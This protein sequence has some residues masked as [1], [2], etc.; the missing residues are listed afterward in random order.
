MTVNEATMKLGRWGLKLSPDTPRA[1]LDRIDYFGHIA[2]STGRIDPR[3]AGD[4]LL[5]SARYVGV[6]RS[7]QLADEGSGAASTLGGCS[8]AFWLGDEAKKG[9][10]IENATPFAS[11]SFTSTVRAL[12][13]SSGAVVEGTLHSVTGLYN[14]THQY[15]DPRTAISYVCEFFSSSSSDPVEWRVNGDATLDAGHVSDLYETTPKAAIVRRG[16][17][18]DMNLRALAGKATTAVDVED[19]TTRVVLLAN[20]TGGSVATG[21]ADISPG[22]NT[23]K[24]LHGNTVVMTRLVSESSTSQG[25][26]TSRAQLSL[27]RF[28]A[29][30][31]ALTLSSG[32]Y[33]VRGTASVGDAVWVWNPDV[34]LLD[35]N[36][37]ILHRG[38][39]INPVKL[40]LTEMTW[41]IAE[42]MSVAYRDKNGGW[43]DLTDYVQWES[44][45][46]TLVVGGYDRSLTNTGG[47]PVGSR[48]VRDTSVPG[49]PAF[50]TGAFV[51]SVYQS[52]NTG[53]TKARVQL[54]WTQPTN[55]DGTV[56]IDGDRYELRYRTSAHSIFPSL[57]E[58][59]AGFNWE[60]LDTWDQPINLGE[61][62]WHYLAVS[63]DTTQFL[64][65]E[66]TPGV[67]Y[68]FQIRAADNASPANLSDWSA[69]TTI[70]THG[71]TI[72][73]A[74]PAPPTVAASL[75]AVQ[76]I[77]TL[78]ISEGGTY[79]LDPDLHHLEVHAEYEPTFTPSDATR[80][81]KLLANVGMMIGEIPVVGTLPVESTAALYFKVIAVDEAGNK[82]SPS[83]AV[84]ATADLIDNAHISDLS[85]SKLT[86]GTVTAAYVHAG[87]LRIGAGTPGDGI[88]PA[89]ELT[90][91]SIQAFNPTDGLTFNLD[92]ATGDVRLSGTV[93]GKGLLLEA[94]FGGKLEVKDGGNVTRLIARHD[95]V[96]I[97]DSTGNEVFSNTT[98]SDWGI[99]QPNL[100][101]A[102][103][104][105]NSDT[106]TQNNTVD[107]AYYAKYL[108]GHI[109]NHARVNFGVVCSVSGGGATGKYRVR[110][111]TG[112]PGNGGNPSG[113]TLMAERTGIAQGSYIDGYTYDWPSNMFG[114]L[115][116]IAY[117]VGLTSGVGGSDWVSATPSH[118]FGQ[119]N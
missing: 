9:A 78:G 52:T 25:N 13:P 18:L 48:P 30:R 54:V 91:G 93:Y 44:G 88:G 114:Q 73:P 105:V 24:D 39:R 19:F 86:A 99:T 97:R 89:V 63:F 66:L 74:T 32:E 96:T 61:G 95:E 81:G 94:G 14:N 2:I 46:T 51:Q 118:F 98:A 75:I 110:W 60:D 20:G 15:Q 41:P 117:E 6:L 111:Y 23:Y 56:I 70:Q 100:Q 4:S 47:E 112:H 82:S 37:E 17:G 7:R 92:A 49:T 77:H 68:D 43:V 113:G 35:E 67:P 3:V 108:S 34:G 28:T 42:G 38:W 55:T 5:T 16:A 11:G 8:M 104:P 26:A 119:G 80:I 59:V 109:I 65:Q 71:D 53:I 40:R 36:N 103:Y 106:A 107:S 87:W 64:V 115:V 12:L 57:W 85:V 69:S 10:V 27:N 83:T 22:L 31:T 45:N 50:N 79:N 90:P 76:V 33:D 21:S 29:P 84:V 58:E 72:A 116:Y 62:E 101:S 1:V 102:F